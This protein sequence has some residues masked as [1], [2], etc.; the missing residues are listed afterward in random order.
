MPHFFIR[1][2][3]WLFP[4]TNRDNNYN[5]I[6]NFEMVFSCKNMD[7][8]TKK[9]KKNHLTNGDQDNKILTDIQD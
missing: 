9:K 7:L 8:L 3:E 4:F 2:F 1:V 6:F 5:L